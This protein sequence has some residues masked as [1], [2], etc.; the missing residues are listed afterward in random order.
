MITLAFL[1]LRSLLLVCSW[2]HNNRDAIPGCLFAYSDSANPPVVEG[3]LPL[4][5]TLTG[6][7][8]LCFGLASSHQFYGSSCDSAEVCSHIFS[9]F[10]NSWSILPWLFIAYLCMCLWVVVCVC[11][12]LL[13]Y[14][15]VLFFLLCCYLL[16]FL[17]TID[18]CFETH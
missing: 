3:A 10:S 7:W 6:F 17:L 8:G 11:N 1:H 16:V 14:L 13:K 5:T 4:I 2:P 18:V 12:L 9:R 15:M